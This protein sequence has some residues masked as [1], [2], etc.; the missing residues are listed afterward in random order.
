MHHFIEIG[1]PATLSQSSKAISMDSV[2]NIIKFLGE[3]SQESRFVKL[4]SHACITR[5]ILTGSRQQLEEMNS[6]I[7]ESGIKPVIKDR[8]FS[9]HEL[10]DAT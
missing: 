6:A 2:I 7:D 10:K 5:G 8:V 3:I 4:L 9:F 1:D